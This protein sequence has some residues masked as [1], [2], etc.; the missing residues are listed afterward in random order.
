MSNRKHL[1]VK[2]KKQYPL[3]QSSLYRLENKK[4]LAQILNIELEELKKYSSSNQSEY[5]VF[6][7]EKGRE[8]QA[9]INAIYL[10][11]NRLANLLSRIETPSWFDVC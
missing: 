2:N 7:N 6:L 5:N 9:P 10:V 11:H 8:I 4:K 1:K 3:H